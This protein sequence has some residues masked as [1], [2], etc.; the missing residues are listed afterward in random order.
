MASMRIGCDNLVFAPLVKDNGTELT[1]GTAVPLPGLMKI[2]ITPNSS[3]ATAFYDNGPAESAA[4]MGA[5]EV[6]IDKSALST[7]EEALLLGHTVDAT[8]GVIVSAA[9]DVAPEGAIGFRTLKSNGKYKYVWLLKGSF[10]EPE[11]ETETK[12]ESVNFQNNTLVGNFVKTTTPVTIGGKKKQAWKVA[13]D[14]EDDKADAATIIANWFNKPYLPG[15]AALSAT[16][17]N[18]VEVEEVVDVK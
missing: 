3:N 4:T 6:S 9:D 5:I 2:G 18:D 14:E 8:T 13:V 12:G 11:E 7:A 17:E 15:A 16:S 10:A 1:Y